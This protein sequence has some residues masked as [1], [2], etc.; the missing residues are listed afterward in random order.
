MEI[1]K[2]GSWRPRGGETLFR[3]A[4]G[5]EGI[6][7]IAGRL[8]TCRSGID[9]DIPVRGRVEVPKQRHNCVGGGINL[10]NQV[11]FIGPSDAGKVWRMSDA[12]S[13]TTS[14]AVLSAE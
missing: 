1:S 12:V 7:R 14:I 9:D 11:G 8:G 5:N 4:N 3:R 10:S 6:S 2:P 13:D